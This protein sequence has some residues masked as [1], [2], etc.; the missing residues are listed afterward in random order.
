LK[1][2]CS[3]IF[4]C[5]LSAGI[6]FGPG[7]PPPAHAAEGSLLEGSFYSVSLSRQM[8]YRIFLPPGCFDSRTADAGYPV[9]YLLHGH[10]EEE[11]YLAHTHWTER[12]EVAAIANAYEMIIVFPE[13]L[14][15]WYSNYHDSTP[16]TNRFEDYM[17]RDLIGHMD[18]TYRTR[19]ER[20]S[21]AIAGNSMG[22]HGAMKLAARRPDLF[23]AAASLSGIF[24][25]SLA[26]VASHLEPIFPNNMLTVFGPHPDNL[27]YYQGNSAVSLA[28]NFAAPGGADETSHMRLHFNAGL[29]DHYLAP[30]WAIEYARVLDGLGIPYDAA[31]YGGDWETAGHNWT[32]W[33]NHIGEVLDFV[34][35]VFASPPDRPGRWRYRTIESSFEVWGWAFH[36]SRPAF[37]AWIELTD[38]GLEGFDLMDEGTTRTLSVEAP[39]LYEPGAEYQ[40]VAEDSGGRILSEIRETADESGA[41]RFSLDLGGRNR[42]SGSGENGTATVH[43]EIFEGWESASGEGHCGGCAHISHRIGNRG[44]SATAQ[45]AAD[46]TLFLL[47]IG[48]LIILLKRNQ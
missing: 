37:R 2:V 27:I 25:L 7:G 11:N 32:Y 46:L 38:A 35:A 39:S 36:A 13:G 45:I 3:F 22:G 10:E 14:R 31:I 44:M 26:G 19:P 43:V 40:I 1:K 41:L 12:T 15:S 42:D 48:A 23:C 33:G 30:L 29:L 47:P 28:A 8:P 34:S 9:L 5:V 21:R 6:A 17:V 4:L 16:G 20:E 18:E 24:D